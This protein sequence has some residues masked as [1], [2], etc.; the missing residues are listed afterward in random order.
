[1]LAAGVDPVQHFKSFGRKE[2][3]FSAF[4]TLSVFFD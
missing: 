4:S 3:R 1:V 2:G